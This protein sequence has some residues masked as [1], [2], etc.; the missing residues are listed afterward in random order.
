MKERT[1]L[2]KRFTSD[3]KDMDSIVEMLE[4]MA[5][6]GWELTSKTGGMY[7]FRKTEPRKVKISVELVLADD[8]DIER[9]RFVEY[10]EACGWKHIFSDGKVQIFE[11]ED[12]DAEPIHS[13]PEV[14][15]AMIHKKSRMMYQILPIL[16]AMGTLWFMNRFMFPIE[17]YNLISW[18]SLLGYIGFPLMSII[19]VALGIDYSLWYRKAK[20]SVQKGEHPSYRQSKFSKNADKILCTYI[21]LGLWG[22]NLLDAIYTGDT[23]Q[24]VAMTC[25]LGAVGVFIWLFPRISAKHT[26]DHEGNLP[27]YIVLGVAIVIVSIGVMVAVG[28]SDGKT[29]ANEVPLTFSDLDM[30]FEEGTSLWKSM[31]GSFIAKSFFASETIQRDYPEEDDVVALDGMNYQIY[32]TKY[33]KAYELLLVDCFDS[34]VEDYKEIEEPAFGANTVYYSEAEQQW[35][36]L[37]DER[38]ITFSC[39]ENLNDGQKKIVAKK[40]NIEL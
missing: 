39:S 3:Y 32:E 18:N 23:K 8:N 11:T 28:S 13:D 22:T 25:L 2:T 40:L 27:L 6:Q 34:Y 12:L 24:V 4:N 5:A 30:D 29:T 38:I 21:F 37:Y 36:L 17:A 7:G 9:K 33:P 31:E 1:I 20:L 15:L 14:K 16:M 19:L 35:L 10:C 26:H